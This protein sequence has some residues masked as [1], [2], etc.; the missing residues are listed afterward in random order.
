[1]SYFTLHLEEPVE[2][3]KGREAFQFPTDDPM[4]SIHAD[5]EWT[6]KL[7]FVNRDGTPVLSELR[8]FP[9]E[10]DTI[11]TNP[12]T[13]WS[14]DPDAVPGDGLPAAFVKNLALG[15]VEN[16]VRQALADH[17]HPAWPGDR[18]WHED[19]P[20]DHYLEWLDVT[21]R[22][23]IDPKR[24]ASPQRRGRPAL[25]DEHLAEVALHY[26]TALAAGI[27]TT[28]Y[29]H[30]QMEHSGENLPVSQWVDKARKRGYLTQPS[31]PGRP[32]GELTGKA[33]A[34]IAQHG[35]VSPKPETNEGNGQ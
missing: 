20:P 7:R 23:G 2:P 1:M 9:T 32:G 28:S 17:H 24:T 35:L 33:K 30:A 6:V 29:V 11:D 8:I 14:G 5:D 27:P 22:T 31:K 16:Q 10:P 19:E 18:Q 12:P 3:T 13:D 25:S 21:S 15:R 34:V 4:W 26:T